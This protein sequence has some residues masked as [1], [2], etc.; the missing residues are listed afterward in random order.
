MSDVDE[1]A[2]DASIN[3]AAAIDYWNTIQ[4]T[5]NG[6][7][8]GFPQVSRIELQGSSNFYAK[9]RRL[10]GRQ[11][12]ELVPHAVDCGA[13]IG[14]VTAG[15]LQ[16]VA[17]VIDIVEPVKKFTD[18][19]QAEA[20]KDL[21]EQGRVGT[22]YNSGLES[23]TST[24]SYKYD[25]IWNQWCLGH[26]TDAQLVE[27]FVRCCQYLAEGGLIVVKE[28]MSS[29]PHGRDLFDEEDSSVTRTE[30]KFRKLFE[31]SGLDLVWSEVQRGMP[32]GLYGVKM[33]ALRPKPRS[34]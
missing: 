3:H 24:A 34:A 27:Y 30:E 16:K 32:K 31:E 9:V 21:F 1:D 6:M 11:T 12:S 22:I 7:L 8:G 33:F 13:G 28:N 25:L 15:F 26:L 17:Q 19:L 23:W 2:P 4:P 29:D 20:C 5:V 10:T 14:R 18:E